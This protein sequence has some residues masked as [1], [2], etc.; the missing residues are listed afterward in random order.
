MY[1]SSTFSEEGSSCRQAKEPANPKGWLVLGP[2]CGIRTH[3]LLNPNKLINFFL[4]FSDH[5]RYFLICFPFFPEL[6][7]PL[8][9]YTPKPVVVNY[10]VKNRFLQIRQPRRSQKAVFT[11]RDCTLP[12][13]H[14]QVISSIKNWSTINKEKGKQYIS[15]VL[16]T[17]NSK[18]DNVV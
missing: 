13:P 14:C 7:R 8:S 12:H 15:N 9:P 2:D 1:I 10:V 18:L 17:V 3:G 16:Q 6:L 11:L 5:F 4:I